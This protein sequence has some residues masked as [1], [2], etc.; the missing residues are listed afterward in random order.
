MRKTHLHAVLLGVLAMVLISPDALIIRLIEADEALALAARGFL[1]GF[2]ILAGSLAVHRLDWRR[3][4]VDGIR[5]KLVYAVSFCAGMFAFTYAVNHT[6]VF[7]VLVMLTVAPLLAGLGAQFVRKE[8]I[9][10]ALWVTSA[11]VFLCVLVILWSDLE[12]GH[13]LGDLA[14]LGTAATLAF[15]SN[16][17]RHVP[18]LDTVTGLGIGGLL[19]VPLALPFAGGLALGENDWWL[20]LLGPGLL[21]PIAVGLHNH[22]SKLLPPPE[23]TLLFTIEMALSPL[24][25]WHFLGELP[26][27]AGLVAGICATALLVVYYS[28][29]LRRATGH[30]QDQ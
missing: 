5:V 3:M 13:V 15:N 21:L 6:K 29:K 16:L 17:V 11:A 4:F 26:E 14:A 7:N 30:A 25:V 12:A 27:P 9:D 24:L 1:I 10:R 23:V 28:G 19:V 8:R 18:R 22:V 20:L 2:A